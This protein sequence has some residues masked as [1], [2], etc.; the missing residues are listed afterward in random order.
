MKLH[1]SNSVRPA[2]SACGRKWVQKSKD[3]LEITCKSCQTTHAY[4]NKYLVRI[5]KFTSK[6]QTIQP[7]LGKPYT[8]EAF[9]K[10]YDPVQKICDL[11]FIHTWNNQ[12]IAQYM[13]VYDWHQ[14]VTP[15]QYIWFW[16]Q[17]Y[18]LGEKAMIPYLEF[19]YLI[20]TLS[21]QLTEP[22]LHKV[23]SEWL[24]THHAMQRQAE[25]GIPSECLYFVLNHGIHWQEA[26]T[27]IFKMPKITESIK[28]FY[29]W[30]HLKVVTRSNKII[31]LYQDAR[32]LSSIPHMIQF[33]KT[34]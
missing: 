12:P 24:L 30:R 17:C 23:N 9:V 15:R 21:P 3:V 11:Q 18:G 32:P 22:R 8:F 20:K 29:P 34:P 13:R 27:V 19:K 26:D 7:Y 16:A 1:L 33:K 28:K 5:E 14:T 31:T 4:T 25:R 6:L 10:E 2:V